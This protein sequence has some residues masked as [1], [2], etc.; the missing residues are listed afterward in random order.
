M[1]TIESVA[2]PRSGAALWLRETRAY[3]L[4]AS[5]MPVLVAV[6]LARCARVPFSGWLVAPVLGTALLLH[7]GTN[8]VNDAEDLWNGVDRPGTTGGSGLLTAGLLDPTWVRRVGVGLLV[9]AGFVG[10]PVILA[11]GYPVLVL[12]LVGAFGGFAY[13]AGPAYKYRGLGDL[14]VFVLM[15]PGL[16]TASLYG[17][18]GSADAALLGRAALA[19]LPVALLVTAVLAVNNYRDI[20]DD[21]AAGIRTLA[22]V[23]GPRWARRYAIA[24]VAGAFVATPLLVLARVLPVWSLAA[25]VAGLPAAGV[26]R[27]LVRSRDGRACANT[28][29]VERT[30]G[31]HAVYG[32]VLFATLLATPLR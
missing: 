25:L 6:G 10:M 29:L 21:A 9:A 24:L 14:G 16:V 23:L 32:A 30:A 20:E 1:S 19:S 18:T 27:E 5:V 13:T 3:S 8:L 28:R 7:L 4:T 2:R 11:R 31:V 15:G 12:G 22:H 26:L 17:L